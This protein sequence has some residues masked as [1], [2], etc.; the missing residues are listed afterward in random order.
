VNLA[1]PRAMGYRRTLMGALVCVLALAGAG[2]SWAQSKKDAGRATAEH[3][4][5]AELFFRAGEQ[6]FNAGQYLVA[7]QA[8]EQSYEILPLPAIL[9]STAQAYRLQ[10][11]ID[12]DVAH[13]QRAI[14]LYRL[15]IQEVEQGGRR[16]DAATSLA[17]LEV[18]RDRLQ[19]E[20]RLK[21]RR[22]A[23]EAID[24]TQLMVTTQTEGAKASIDGKVGPAPLILEVE[25]GKH[26]VEVEA[27][28]YFPASQ[29]ATAV[30][31][32]LIV[33][34]VALAPMPALLTVHAEPGA[35]IHVDGRVLA[36]T[37]LSRP[38]EISAGKRFVAITRRGRYPWAREIELVHGQ[39]LELRARLETTSQRRI[40]FWVLG[41]SGLSLATAGGFGFLAYQ[42]DRELA[43]LVAKYNGP[44]LS[45]AEL[46]TLNALEDQRDSRR[47]ITYGLL[48]ATAL[49]ALA[50][51]LLYWFDTP[52]ISTVGVSSSGDVTPARDKASSL[53]ITPIIDVQ[54]AGFGV[55]GRF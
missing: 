22:E 9:F 19:R 16:Q 49:T 3:R 2:V 37:P 43:P 51:G 34:E 48:G 5:E 36:T 52:Q 25:P 23:V 29:Q 44:G 15:Y 42:K 6:A 38:V 53:R 27:E 41:A 11:F 47:R 24:K 26:R 40:S 28:G 20:G 1:I 7:A 12:K 14:E 4:K 18:L 35:S 54:Q 55:A 33:V 32:R 13:L 45:D 17:E 39:P 50:G 8:F 31:G 21:S 46:D 10:Y 30:A